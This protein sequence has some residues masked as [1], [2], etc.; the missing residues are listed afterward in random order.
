VFSAVF[1]VPRENAWV[2]RKIGQATRPFR[3]DGYP[4]P[5]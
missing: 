5:A 4:V 3:V 1:G 2:G